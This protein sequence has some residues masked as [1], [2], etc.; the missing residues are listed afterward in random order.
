LEAGNGPRFQ[1]FTSTPF[2]AS[3]AQDKNALPACAHLP[4]RSGLVQRFLSL[5][6]AEK[7]EEVDCH[8]KQA[9]LE[10]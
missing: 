8:F 3:T 7:K 6:K 9:E 4:P 2:K 5:V 10:S 1:G